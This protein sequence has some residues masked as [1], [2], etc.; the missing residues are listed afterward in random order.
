VG[1]PLEDGQ[2]DVPWPCNPD[3]RYIV[4]FTEEDNLSVMSYGSGYGGNALL[5]KKCYA[6]RIASVLARKEGWL[7]EH[8][9]IL[10]LTSPEVIGFFSQYQ[11]DNRKLTVISQGKKYYICAGFPSACG[12]TNLAMLVPTIPGWTVKC[13][14][15]H[16][17]EGYPVE[18][19]TVNIL[20]ASEMILLG[21]ILEKM[22]SCTPSTQNLVSLVLL[23]ELQM[24]PIEV[25]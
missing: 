21:F 15:L 23:L 19:L 17:N 25:R 8:N 7:A 22:A 11:T 24:F 14:S 9:L 3:N 20:G 13:V 6:L 4:H 18:C 16:I 1:Y 2:K 5:G 10:G 12:K